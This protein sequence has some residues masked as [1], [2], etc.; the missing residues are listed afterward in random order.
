MSSTSR[1]PS[2]SLHT[3]FGR[4][5]VKHNGVVHYIGKHGTKASKAGYARLLAQWSAD[6]P[7]RHAS[8][9][10]VAHGERLCRR[11]A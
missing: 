3:P 5:I 6:D 2:Y 10:E 11:Q 9:D 8:H 1:V 7:S 4:T